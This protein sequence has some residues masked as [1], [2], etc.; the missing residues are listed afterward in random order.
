MPD[1]RI[2]NKSL[3]H[4]DDPAS[5][6]G[7]ERS[8]INDENDR[9]MYERSMDRLSEIVR[10]NPRLRILFWSLAGRE[11]ENRRLGKYTRDG[12][13]RHPVW[14]LAEAESAFGDSVVSMQDVLGSPV[15]RLMVKDAQ[16]HPSEWGY[17]VIRRLIDAPDRPVREH[18]DDVES[19]MVVPRLV[20]GRPTVITG[21]SH[22]LRVVQER[23]DE[24]RV[25][26]EANVRIEPEA[27]NV[28]R[29]PEGGPD[30]VW[31]SGLHGGNHRDPE[32]G[33]E[34]ESRMLRNL[35]DRGFH[36]RVLTWSARAND[37][38][39]PR[40]APPPADPASRQSIDRRLN[41][42][43]GPGIPLLTEGPTSPPIVRRGHVELD[44]PVPDGAIPSIEGIVAAM[45]GVRGGAQWEMY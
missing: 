22:W 24:G 20:I 19:H 30:L 1:F 37:V 11:D 17:E 21:T 18:L 41:E 2:G 10:A 8:L 26:L 39:H 31:M 5:H 43:T 25:R 44:S 45:R 33:I 3:T 9:R 36:P 28:P 6:A 29:S 13:Y 15:A 32:S 16:L 4:P 42:K 35:R 38:L 40:L 27:G 14:N 7:I 34:A 12:V 23:V